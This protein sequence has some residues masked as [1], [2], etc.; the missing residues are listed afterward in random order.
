MVLIRLAAHVS[1]RQQLVTRSVFWIL[2]HPVVGKVASR[3]D[4]YQVRRGDSAPLLGEEI[5]ESAKEHQRY[6]ISSNNKFKNLT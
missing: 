1:F 6:I 4:Y 2:K 5:G 3:G